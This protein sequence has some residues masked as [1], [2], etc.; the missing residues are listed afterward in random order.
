MTN[1][2]SA[3]SD[4]YTLSSL[5][6]CGDWSKLV[7][8]LGGKPILFGAGGAT[9]ARALWRLLRF[10]RR[11][12]FDAIYV[13]GLRAAFFLRFMRFFL[14]KT[15]IVCGVR[16][17]PSS[18]TRLDRAF[19][20]IERCFGSLVDGYITNSKAA[21]ETLERRCRIKTH[22]IAV[23]YNGV[24][25][26]SV[27]EREPSYEVLTVANLI[28]LKGHIAY[29][30]A[31]KK[32]VSRFANARFVFV[33]RDDMNGEVQR[34]VEKQ[35]LGEFVRFEGFCTD[36]APFYRRASVFVLP[37]FSEG[38]PTSILEAFSYALPVVAYAIDGIPELISGDGFLAT[39]Y[40]SDE[41]AEH[42]LTL[43]E[44]PDL[45]KTMGAKGRDKIAENFTLSSCAKAHSEAIGAF[46]RNA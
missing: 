6:G 29:L 3:S 5:A 35:N 27:C 10:A 22:K 46:I 24:K 40:D 1:M 45:A 21:K 16:W 14:P 44:N 32:V 34:E 31:V 39:P 25:T 36:V 42:I 13:C 4:S 2:A 43:L 38:S 17:N 33:G 15:A 37:S 19:S 18:S 26:T 9:L 20:L 28:W 30:A 11:E 23:I 41:L 12:R 7:T 8:A